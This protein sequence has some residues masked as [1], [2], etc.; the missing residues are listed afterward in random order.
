MIM[1][2]NM[3]MMKVYKKKKQEKRTLCPTGLWTPYNNPKN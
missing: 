2:M 1:T 3:M